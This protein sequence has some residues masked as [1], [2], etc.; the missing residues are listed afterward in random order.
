MEKANEKGVGVDFRSKFLQVYAVLKSEL[1]RDPAFE[2]DDESRRWIDRVS[3]QISLRF[4]G[5][6]T[7]AFRLWRIALDTTYP[8]LFDYIYIHAFSPVT[9]SC[10]T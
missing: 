2:Y 3:N 4:A 7:W 10:G 1:L 5:L 8:S 6:I 9:F